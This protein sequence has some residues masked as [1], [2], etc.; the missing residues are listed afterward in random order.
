VLTEPRA[1]AT[2]TRPEAAGLRMTWC[3]L[4]LDY[5][6]I[7]MRW[8]ISMRRMDFPPVTVGVGNFSAVD[9]LQESCS[10]MNGKPVGPTTFITGPSW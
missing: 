1:D 5:W 10:L 4:R 3:G 8:G 9:V 2:G 7:L 6:S